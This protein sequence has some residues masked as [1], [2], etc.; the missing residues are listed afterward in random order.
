MFEILKHP[1]YSRLF[2][3]QVIALLGTGLLTVALGLLAFDLAGESAGT[4]LGTAFAIKMIAYVGLAPVANA[5]AEKLPLKAILIGADLIRACVTIFLPFIDSVWQIYVLI[6]V[7]QAASATFTP[8]FQ[9]VI[10]D[11]L[12]KEKDYTKALSLSRFAYDLENL[13]SPA[14]AGVLL[15][16]MSYHWLFG[17]TVIGFLGSATLVAVTPIPARDRPA[18]YRPFIKRLTRGIQIY[19]ATPRL[20]GLLALNMA[21][22]ATGAFVLINTVVI[23]RAGYGAYE[24]DVA[25]ALAAFGDGSMIAAITLPRI[26]DALPDRKIMV[27][28]AF[29]LAGLTVCH[30]IYMLAEGRLAWVGF[31]LAWAASG[32]LYSAILTP[33]GRLLRRS[34]HAEDRPAIFAAQFALSHACW[35]LTYPVAGW[36]GD[37]FGLAP[38]MMILGIL[39]L[40][41]SILSLFV[42]PADDAEEL[43]HSHPHLP[44]DHPH[45]REYQATGANH[46]HAFVIDDEHRAW[47]THG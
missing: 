7:L 17:G 14:L 1:V 21:A 19:L 31:L 45:F 37:L 34:A 38:A 24:T 11:I 8:A 46:R 41:G 13:V 20:R 43:T 30:A 28:A 10:P 4:V 22:A 44:P 2:S 15:T 25:Y 35:L 18:A 6:F 33:S 47:P 3:A 9:A 36:A 32:M 23:V 12:A 39:A 26:L 5:F 27:S 16:I 40:A 42:W 29:L